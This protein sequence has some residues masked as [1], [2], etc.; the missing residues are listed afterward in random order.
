MGVVGGMEIVVEE[1]EPQ[2]RRALDDS[3]A[4]GNDAFR[5]VL[6][7]GADE[8]QR[9]A[10]IDED[11][12]IGERAHAADAPEPGDH[13]GAAEE[14]P[15]PDAGQR[16]VAFEDRPALVPQEAR[17][18]PERAD[19]EPAGEAGLR[20]DEAAGERAETLPVRRRPVVGF[21][22]VE[23]IGQPLVTMVAEMH[24]PVAGKRDPQRQRYEAE[25]P[26][27]SPP[28]RRMAVDDFV[29]QRTVPGDDPGRGGHEQHQRDGVV[30]ERQRAP[31][32][33]DRDGE[34]ERRPLDDRGAAEGFCIDSRRVCH[35]PMIRANPLD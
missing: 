5:L 7:K 1:Q 29:L 20:L 3:G 35:A 23:G 11:R 27:Q 12:Q 2:H 33:I 24:D 10:R 26:V 17:D 21:R 19:D 8:E 15:R 31:T 4:L 28:V 34:E 18:R 6:G 30:P 32:A 14:M 13:H 25:R 9:R 16:L 22:V